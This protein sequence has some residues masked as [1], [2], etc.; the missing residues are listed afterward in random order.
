MQIKLFR[1]KLT[2]FNSCFSVWFC[3]EN[4]FSVCLS[5]ISKSSACLLLFNVE[6]ALIHFNTIKSIY[7]FRTKELDIKNLKLL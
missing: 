7:K 5:I 4:S 1:D 2:L 6:S 3:N